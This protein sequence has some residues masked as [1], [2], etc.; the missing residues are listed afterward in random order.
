MPRQKRSCPVCGST[1]LHVAV[2][3][4]FGEVWDCVDCKHHWE[5]TF[6]GRLNSEEQF[7]ESSNVGN[8]L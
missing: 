1:N 5:I 8:P 4:P 2:W 7:S 3:S 6:G